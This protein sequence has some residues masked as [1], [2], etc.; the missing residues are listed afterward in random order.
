M[1]ESFKY[2]TFIPVSVS[3]LR[4]PVLTN[5]L[6]LFYHLDNVNCSGNEDMLSECEHNGV[7]VHDCSVGYE[8]AGVIC[9]CMFL[10]LSVKGF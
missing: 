2:F 10:L 7:G 9:N 3:L 5:E 1:H 6:S 4:Y 8:E